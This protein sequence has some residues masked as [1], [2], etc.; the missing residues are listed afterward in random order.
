MKF[1]EAKGYK[2]YAPAYA[3]HEGKPTDLRY[4]IDQRLGQL[5]FGQVIDNY[6][7]LLTNYP[8]KQSLE[9][10]QWVIMLYKN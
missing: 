4:N 1:Y 2:H 7:F 9:G 8:K 5:S 6:L 10:T 3:Y